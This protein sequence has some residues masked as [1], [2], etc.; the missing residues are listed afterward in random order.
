VD[1][2]VHAMETGTVRIKTRQAEPRHERRERRLLDVLTDRKWTAPLPVSCYAIEHPEG[3]IV[4]DTGAN[5]RAGKPGYEPRWHLLAQRAARFS[6]D[7]AEEVGPRLSTLG[8]DPRSAATVVMTH[9]HG[10]HAGGLSYFEGVSVLMTEREASIATGRGAEINAYFRRNHP[11]WLK[12]STVRF[13]SDPWE[14][15]D[16]SIAL[17]CDGAIRLIPTPGHT[18][19][20]LSVVIEQ[21]DHLVLLAGDAV[22]SEQQLQRGTIDGVAESAAQHRDSMRRIRELCTRRNV[23]VVPTHDPEGA[24]RLAERRYT[25]VED[26]ATEHKEKSDAYG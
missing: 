1:V 5:T 12:P 6:V 14:T 19:G 9:M 4:V 7:A 25:V 22:Y 15:F 26:P 10:D 17:T 8:H 21:G 13:D 24:R 20:H 16:A 11:R 23:I 3:M 2:W 18:S